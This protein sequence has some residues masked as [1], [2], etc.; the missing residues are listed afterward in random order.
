[1]PD[2][3]EGQKH[4]RCNVQSP[5]TTLTASELAGMTFRAFSLVSVKAWSLVNH[6]LCCKT[7]PGTVDHVI[8][9]HIEKADGLVLPSNSTWGEADCFVQYQ[10]PSQDNG[11]Y[12]QL[13]KVWVKKKGKGHSLR[14]RLFLPYM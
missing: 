8:E 9:L 3:G 7:C 13:T 11:K 4:T 10:F 2:D 12:M 1:M 5:T 6:R 14:S